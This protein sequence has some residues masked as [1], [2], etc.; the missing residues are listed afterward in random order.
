M[1]SDHF[2]FHLLHNR[3]RKKKK[4]V[5][6]MENKKTELII[7]IDKSG[8]M[9]SLQEDVIGGY[10]A[11]I[12]EQKKLGPASVTIVAFNHLVDIIAEDVDIEKVS[13]LNKRNYSPCGCTALLDAVGDTISLIKAK[14][15][16][17]KEEELPEHTIFSIVTDGLENSSREYSYAKVKNM[18]EMQT[19]AGWDFIFQAANIDVAKEGDRLGINPSMRASF[20]ANSKG[21]ERQ[22]R[23]LCEKVTSLRKGNSHG[24]GGKS[25]NK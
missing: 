14:H 5:V 4:E 12:E 2:P 6:P 16:K 17:L 24:K 19:K 3:A 11:F 13:P 9:F 8:S 18:I 15:A 25:L 10:N 1:A 20:C 7:I 22:T 21:V 23:F